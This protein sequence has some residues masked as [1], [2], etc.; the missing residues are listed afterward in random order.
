MSNTNKLRYFRI[1]LFVSL[2]FLEQSTWIVVQNKMEN[3]LNPNRSLIALFHFSTEKNLPCLVFSQQIVFNA[4]K[5]VSFAQ[6]TKLDTNNP[7]SNFNPFGCHLLDFT[8]VSS[9]I[10]LTFHNQ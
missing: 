9:N 2:G 5:C 4:L 10:K 1:V 7:N 8:I 3:C 6:N